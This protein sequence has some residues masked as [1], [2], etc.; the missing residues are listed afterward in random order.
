MLHELYVLDSASMWTAASRTRG[1]G[2]QYV[3]PAERPDCAKRAKKPLSFAASVPWSPL[4]AENGSE[5]LRRLP[6]GA[7]RPEGTPP[8]QNRRLG[9]NGLVLQR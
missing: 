1:W 7:V 2:D 9:S 5:G 8:S 4:D 6:I 3:R